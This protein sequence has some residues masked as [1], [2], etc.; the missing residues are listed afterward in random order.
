[1]QVK[2]T[3]L[4][5][6]MLAVEHLE[7]AEQLERVLQAM[8]DDARAALEPVVLGSRW[9]PVSVQASLHEAIRKELGRGRTEANYRVAQRAIKDD[10][11]GGVYRTFLRLMT[12]DAMWNVSQRVWRQY[13]SSGSVKF[14]DRKRG[15]AR[16]TIEDVDGYTLPMWIA[17][18]GRFHGLLEL[19]GAR[20]VKVETEQHDEISCR[21]RATWTP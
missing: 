20:N 4:R 17:I 3:A 2:G 8:P 5:S 15:H 7:G 1:M 11:K 13:N 6:I 19:A 21:M 14:F 18:C 10:F 9:Y 12:Y 16:G